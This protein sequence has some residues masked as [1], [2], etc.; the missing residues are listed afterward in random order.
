MIATKDS[1]E[2][3]SGDQLPASKRVYVEGRL[4]PG[5]RVPLREIELTPTKTFSGAIEPNEPVRV[6]D[7][8]G[9]W[10]DP[11]FKGTVEQGLPALRREWILKRDDVEESNG[12]PVKPIDDGYLSEKHRG[13]ADAKHQ[14]ETPFHLDQTAL[15][16][17]RILRAKPGKAA[18]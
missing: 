8:S 10:G 9:P 3:Q 14:D 17:R 12:R 1:F 4:H 7:C 6:Y 16:G 15:P 5:I 11:D 13:L 18:T 2:P